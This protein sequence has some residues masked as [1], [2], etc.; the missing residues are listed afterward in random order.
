MRPKAIR[1]LQYRSAKLAAIAT[2]LFMTMSGQAFLTGGAA[3]AATPT[4][5]YLVAD[6]AMAKVGDEVDIHG[7]RDRGHHPCECWRN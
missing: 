2:V 4:K 5:P 6:R 3:H 1:R 7:P